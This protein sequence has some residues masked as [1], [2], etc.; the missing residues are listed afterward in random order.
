VKQN[1]VTREISEL[2]IQ[3]KYIKEEM[4]QDM[5][6]LRKKNQTETQNTMEDHSSRLEQV[7]DRL[8]ELKDIEIKEKTEEML[9]KELKNCERNMQELTDSIKTSNLRIMGIEGEELQAERI[10]NMFY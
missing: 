1:T 6:N 5:E 9:V 3:I 10:H 8:S 7:E 4:N 2:K